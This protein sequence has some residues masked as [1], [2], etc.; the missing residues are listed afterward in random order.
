MRHERIG[1]ANGIRKLYNHISGKE[2]VYYWIGELPRATYYMSWP[3][4][5]VFAVRPYEDER[6]PHLRDVLLF[7][8]IVSVVGVASLPLPYTVAK[9]L[10]VIFAILLGAVARVI[11]TRTEKKIRF[12]NQ[13]KRDGASC[14]GHFQNGS[15]RKAHGLLRRCFFLSRTSL[16]P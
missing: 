2:T 11:V 7:L 16:L 4:K 10:A 8:S 1:V 9:T 12:L 14:S 3:E 5:E 13:A 6:M 15:A